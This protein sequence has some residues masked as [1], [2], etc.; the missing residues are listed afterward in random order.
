MMTLTGMLLRNMNKYLVLYFP[1]QLLFFS[2]SSFLREIESLGEHGG[3]AKGK[4]EK[5]S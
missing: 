2:F 1:L 5:E 3:G 4:G